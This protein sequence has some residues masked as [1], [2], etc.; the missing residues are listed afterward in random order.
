[1]SRTIGKQSKLCVYEKDEPK[2]KKT[3]LERGSRIEMSD[4]EKI[5]SAAARILCLYRSAFEELAK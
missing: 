5:D 1:M 4:D 2:Y 3:D